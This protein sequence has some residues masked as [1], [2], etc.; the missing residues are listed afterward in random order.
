[1]NATDM[2][3]LMNRSPF[4]S[5]E[6][7]MNDGLRLRVEQPFQISTAPNSSCCTVYDSSPE[8][9]IISYRNIARVVTAA[10]ASPAA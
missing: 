3:K 6:I 9:H 4:E 10:E 2:L 5:F 7:F 8:M 1:M